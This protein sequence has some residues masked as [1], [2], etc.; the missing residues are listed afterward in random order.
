MPWALGTDSTS[1]ERLDKSLLS[2]CGCK[3]QAEVK[4]AVEVPEP[5]SRSFRSVENVLNVKTHRPPTP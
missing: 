2:G 1:K 3:R 4:P 5:A